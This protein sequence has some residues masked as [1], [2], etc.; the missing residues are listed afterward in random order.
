MP[1]TPILARSVM[2][3]SYACSNLLSSRG[4]WLFAGVR[5]HPLPVCVASGSRCS[6]GYEQA[7]KLWAKIT[8]WR[9]P[10]QRGLRRPTLDLC[11]ASKESHPGTHEQGLHHHADLDIDSSDRTRPCLLSA[12]VSSRQLISNQAL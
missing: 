7:C 8:L 6:F 3:T 12:P 2:A 9:E 11:G 4:L 5:A 1:P 10:R